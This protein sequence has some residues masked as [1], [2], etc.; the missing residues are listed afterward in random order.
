VTITELQNELKEIEPKID[1]LHEV[2]GCG[3]FAEITQT[4]DGFFLGRK[5]GDCGFNDF[6]GNPSSNAIERTKQFLH[7]LSSP[8]YQLAYKLLSRF[9]LPELDVV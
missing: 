7:Q 5:E 9:D 2:C 3:L 8:A 6:L 4:S 1:F